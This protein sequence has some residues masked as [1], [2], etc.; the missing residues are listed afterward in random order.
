MMD[1][2]ENFILFDNSIG[3]IV[4]LI[5]RNHQFIKDVNKAVEHFKTTQ[6]KVTKRFD[7]KEEAQKLGCLALKEVERRLFNGFLCQKILRA[8][9]G[10]YTLLVTD[11]TRIRHTDIQYVYRG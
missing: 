9:G 10:G 8:L 5:A 11:R 6:E 2:F 3:S 1:L 7:I 4:K